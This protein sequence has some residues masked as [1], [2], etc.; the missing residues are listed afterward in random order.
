[1]R[2]T[3]VLLLALAL[4]GCSAPG[5]DGEEAAAPTPP[6][7]WTPPPLPTLG[8]IVV[9]PGDSW[10]YTSADGNA[11]SVVRIASATNGTLR[12]VTTTE[13]AGERPSTV[14]TVLDAR[15]LALVS[16]NDPRFGADIVFD[17][18]LSI[19][20][21]AEDHRYQGEIRIQTFLGTLSQPANATITFYGLE[22]ITTPA[23]TF[24]T[25]HYAA[26]ISSSGSFAIEQTRE[27]WFSP[28]VKQAVRLNTD[29]RVEDLVAYELADEASA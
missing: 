1:M 12:V 21:P 7:A 11:S 16:L 6:P 25:Y 29:G 10:N 28:D 24:A 2:A 20:M 26:R 19:L 5:D 4:A 17:P 22:N 3:L 13:R 18:P 14:T 15:T 8:S 9:G 27:L 23:G